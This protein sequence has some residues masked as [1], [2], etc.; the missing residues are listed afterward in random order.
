MTLLG[1]LVVLCTYVAVI[2]TFYMHTYIFEPMRRYKIPWRTISAGALNT[3]G[4][5]SLRFSTK[6]SVYLCNGTRVA[7]GYYG[8]L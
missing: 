6:I 1:A 7:D 8:S 2:L 4:G 5:K 3:R